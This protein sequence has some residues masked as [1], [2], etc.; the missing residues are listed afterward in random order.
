MRLGKGFRMRKK[1]V[2]FSQK[3]L[4]IL[5]APICCASSSSV[6]ETFT[7]RFALSF[8]WLLFILSALKLNNAECTHSIRNTTR[9][10]RTSRAC[11]KEKHSTSLFARSFLLMFRIPYSAH[12]VCSIAHTHTHW[13]STHV[14]IRAHHFDAFNWMFQFCSVS[15]FRTHSYCSLFIQQ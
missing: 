1:N 12:K 4:Y 9:K 7:E 14:G 3:K 5:F 2:P 6:A 11:K 15:S 13:H 8:I 10:I